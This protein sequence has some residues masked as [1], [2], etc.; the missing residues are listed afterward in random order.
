MHQTEPPPPPRL[1][2]EEAL[3]ILLRYEN[4]EDFRG[5]EDE[6]NYTA[7]RK[8]KRPNW[9]RERREEERQPQYRRWQLEGEAHNQQKER[10]KG[11]RKFGR[12]KLDLKNTQQ[13]KRKMECGGR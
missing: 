5:S 1:S 6:R 8:E 4:A 7:F 12:T 3:A 13:M 9:Q 11:T 10:W 2:Y